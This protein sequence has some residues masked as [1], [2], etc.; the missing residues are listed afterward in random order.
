MLRPC[1]ATVADYR[2]PRAEFVFHDDSPIRL[3]VGFDY[4]GDFA[5]SAAEVVE[6]ERAG[7]DRVSVAELY[8]FDA[9]SQ[10]GFLA[11]IT[12][13]VTLASAILPIYSRTPPCWP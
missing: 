9:V 1:D 5:A 2:R 8:S 4:S 12:T 6:Y 10:L 3:G 11:A 7:V 13:T